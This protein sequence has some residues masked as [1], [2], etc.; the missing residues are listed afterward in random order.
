MEALSIS[1]PEKPKK[2]SSPTQWMAFVEHCGRSAVITTRFK[3]DLKRQI[4]NLEGCT[5]HAIVRGKKFAVKA[6]T[7]YDFV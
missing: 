7:A 6:T 3:P 5:V 2:Y 1:E 4:S